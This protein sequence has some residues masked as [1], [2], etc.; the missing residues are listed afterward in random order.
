MRLRKDQALLH[1]GIERLN[2]ASQNHN[3]VVTFSGAGTVKGTDWFYETLPQKI[4]GTFSGI[5]VQLSP[6]R[7]R[8][9]EDAA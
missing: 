2:L 5:A 9:V 6:V 1:R 8:P 3:G 4:S 7:A